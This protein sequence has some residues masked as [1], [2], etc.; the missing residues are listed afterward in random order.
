MWRPFR[1]RRCLIFADGFYEWHKLDPKTKQRFE[2][3]MKSG[4]PFAFLIALLLRPAFE[5]K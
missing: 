1:R 4:K 3:T 5:G 2:F